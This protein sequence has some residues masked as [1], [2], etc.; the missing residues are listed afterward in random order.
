MSQATSVVDRMAS[1][2][3]TARVVPATA[4]PR[5]AP[6]VSVVIPC[7]NYGHYLA[8]SV[9]SVCQQQ[10]GV[11]KEVIIVDDASPDGSGDV[12][13]EIAANNPNVSVIRHRKNR[14]H[15]ATYNHGISEAT[16]D[17]I[18]LLSADDLLTPGSL[19]RA[20]A[21]MES[22]PSVGFVYGHVLEHSGDPRPLP[23]THARGW[24]IWSGQDWVKRRFRTSRNVIRTCEVVMRARVQREIGDYR[25]E[26]PQLGD[27]DMWLRAAAVA[28]VG[29][30]L[31]ADQAFYRIHGS[32]MHATTHEGRYLSGVVRDLQERR[33]TFELL[34]DSAPA[35]EDYVAAQRTLSIEALRVVRRAYS[36]G[37]TDHA[38]AD[39]FQS[40]VRSLREPNRAEFDYVQA[41]AL[42]DFAQETFAGCEDLPQWRAMTSARSSGAAP[43][44]VTR[45]VP[46]LADGLERVGRKVA[47]WPWTRLGS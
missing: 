41:Q 8:E 39:N 40:L 5:R 7:Y 38:V 2:C 23:N 37:T 42:V 26:L 45:S 28:D 47:A 17:Y 9:G 1:A 12:A 36:F 19:A 30:I 21:L 11:S 34:R 3:S 46:L 15:I 44:G 35:P 13:E 24:A 25:P 14:G 20:T 31:G 16:G 6:L 32:N 18:V 10:D 22:E 27:F 43:S 33:L 4:M 29:Y